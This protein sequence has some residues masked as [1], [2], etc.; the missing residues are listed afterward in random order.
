M[1]ILA[2]DPGY[3]R[4]GIALLTAD[5]KN[6]K[7]LHTCCI[8]SDKGDDI[9]ERLYSV[10]SQCEKIIQTHSPEV[11][12]L[13]SLFFNS[14]AK[15]AITIAKVCGA[16]IYLSRK[17]NIPVYHYTPLQV[18]VA[19]TGNGRASKKEVEKMIRLLIEYNDIVVDD[20]IDAVGIG[21]TYIAHNNINNKHV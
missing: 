15:T 19:V 20:V 3:D 13:E 10:V 14:N 17:Y 12:V 9:D 21:L 6:T 7:V 16:L 4:M 2:I 18:K 1:K 11:C 8:T 5:K